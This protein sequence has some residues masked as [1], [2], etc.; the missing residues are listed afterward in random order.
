MRRFRCHFSYVP[1]FE[2]GSKALN[3]NFR[4]ELITH[5]P[6]RNGCIVETPPY[7][8]NLFVYHT[9]TMLWLLGDAIIQGLS[10]HGIDILLFWK[11]RYYSG[12]NFWYDNMRT[13]GTLWS[14][15]GT[16]VFHFRVTPCDK[17][18]SILRC[19]STFRVLVV[20]DRVNYSV[21]HDIGAMHI[22]PWGNRC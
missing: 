17:G 6:A 16:G 4:A 21:S 7:G 20:L 12:M 19:S 15:F 11:I 2:R 1:C 13:G 3:L 8:N 9:Y 18:N 14:M 10:S 5:F 22:F